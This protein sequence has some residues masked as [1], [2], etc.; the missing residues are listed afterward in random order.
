GRMNQ[1]DAK[2]AAVRTKIE[3]AGEVA[4]LVDGDEEARLLSA[5]GR[6]GLTPL[7]LFRWRRHLRDRLGLE[8]AEVGGIA[9][10]G[11]AASIALAAGPL[12]ELLVLAKEEL[13][14]RLRKLELADAAR[15]VQQDGVRQPVET[16]L[17]RIEDRLV[18]GMHQ[19]PCSADLIWSRTS[20][21][22]PEAS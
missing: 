17:E 8:A 21:T 9:A 2:A 16:P 15:S 22:S 4:D 19:R 10:E 13:R 3:K 12:S 1:R 11:P 18:P 7:L 20:A 5:P 6:G 14:H